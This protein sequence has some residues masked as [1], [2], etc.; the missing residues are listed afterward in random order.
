MTLP[1]RGGSSVAGT[2]RAS[3]RWWRPRS[4]DT[5][6]R[7]SAKRLLPAARAA[8]Y[9]GSD[10]NFRR[11][12]AQEK[13]THRQRQATS[14]HRQAERVR[15]LPGSVAARQQL[16]A[17]P[18]A[19]LV[20]GD[21]AARL[22]GR[23]ARR[24]LAGT[25][26]GQWRRRRRLALATGA[27]SLARRARP[28]KLLAR[29]N[30]HRG[31][32]GRDQ[33]RPGTSVAELAGRRRTGTR[34]AAGPRPGRASRPGRFRPD[35]VSRRTGRRHGHDRKPAA[36]PGGADRCGQRGRRQ[37]DHGRGRPGAVRR[38]GRPSVPECWQDLLLPGA[39]RTR[40]LRAGGACQLA[41]AAQ[42]RST[43]A[44][45]AHRPLRVSLPARPRPAGRLPAGTST[46]A[47]LHEPGCTGLLPR[48]AVLGRP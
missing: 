23:A 42:Q 32:A 36:L 28:L 26:D 4:R 40:D 5:K 43:H 15:G 33:R 46:G 14:S 22:A 29:S 12:V 13:S 11:L 1:L 48:Q 20:A 17:A 18:D 21:P 34:W 35:S 31:A 3:G 19:A 44:G 9:A 30:A 45:P 41:G 39:A 8:G 16:S 27:D 10:R 38:R 47:G 2:M 24:Q 7:I 37:L 25:L 6:A